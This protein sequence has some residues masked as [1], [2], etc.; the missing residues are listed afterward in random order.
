MIEL[1]NP[2]LMPLQ[3]RSIDAAALRLMLGDGG[4]LALLD[5]R[6]EGLF[7]E[8]HLFQARPVPLSRLE[9]L[10]PRLVPRRATRLVLCDAGEGLADR[11]AARLCRNGYG[12]LHLL[13]GGPEQWQEA[14][15]QSFSG[16][17]VPGKA[18]GEFIEH[19]D[20]TPGIGAGELARLL[21]EQADMVILDSRPFDEY[22]R[23]SI[24]GACNVPG[25]EL[26]LRARELA[27]SPETM[28]VVNC[29]GRTRSILG[30]QSLINAG[31][32]NRVAALRN[33]IMGWELAGFDC[34]RGQS[35]R[36][37]FPAGPALAAARTAA[38]RVARRFGIERIDGNRLKEMRADGT[39]TLYL[40]D[41]RDPEEYAAGHVAGAVSAPGGQ[42]VQAGDH[43]V[44]TLNARLV[45]IDPAE[46]RAAM[47]ASWLK[48]MG[49]ADVFVLA[50]TGT[51][52]GLP[53]ASVL[54][55]VPAATAIDPVEL[56]SLGGTSA[57]T[58]IDL[59]L[60]RDYT[61][62]HIGS[63][64]FAIR[65]RLDR[66]LARIAPRGLLVL[67]SE[68]GTLA[69]LAAAEAAALSGLAVR[70]LR[71]GNRAWRKAGLPL[72]TESR[73]ADEPIDLWL[74][75]YERAQGV[76]AAMREYLAW[77]TDL[78]GRIAREPSCAF[79]RF[80]AA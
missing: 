11:A 36:A 7:S 37:P 79:R 14:G 9:L 46:I 70:V 57:A 23:M 52:I 42:L 17:N 16:V 30:A 47:T 51:E 69:A 18:F 26:V 29:A 34:A 28:V 35:R 78:L 77:E 33:G 75:P 13:E 59:S 60:S 2:R 25:A 21:R 10:L 71:G 19:S 54:G 62:G 4:E 44:G 65:A 73:M 67:T 31:L 38:Q 45:L 68:D 1:R 66:A 53:Q 74:K 15:L 6:E 58:V 56:A 80:P 32:P 72:S 24:P 55:G 49:W 12:E 27:P 50:E 61:A 63:A 8:G 20:G 5:L 48:Q 64:W 3:S 41:V 22:T 43:Y 76:A 39:R 40:L